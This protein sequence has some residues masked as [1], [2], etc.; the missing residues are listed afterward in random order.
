MKQII[1]AYERQ[2]SWKNKV[3]YND[4]LKEN[5]LKQASRYIAEALS[6]V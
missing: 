3:G 5:I 6:N 1:T 2:F 4:Q